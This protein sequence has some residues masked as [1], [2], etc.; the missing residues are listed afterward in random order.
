MPVFI[1]SLAQQM[2][3]A[4]VQRLETSR[5]L[6]RPMII[7]DVNELLQIFSDAKVVASFGVPPFGLVEMEQWVQHNL[8]HQQANGYGLFSVILKS[9]GTLIGDCGLERMEI[10]GTQTV[11]LGYD[12]RSD[13]WNRGYATEAAI[14]VRDFAFGK[15]KLPQ[16][17]SLIRV[18]NTASRRVAEK[19]GMAYAGELI[20]N[21]KH[22]WRYS[23]EA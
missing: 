3:H 18:G 9:N 23:I 6:L 10:E 15:L 13:H 8:A 4:P 1:G 17:I 21:G 14:A 11:E 12:F 2:N 22:Y 5:L 16:L 7:A 20:H 19:V